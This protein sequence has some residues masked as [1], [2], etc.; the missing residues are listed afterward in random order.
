M[1]ALN[2]IGWDI[3][4]M[5]WLVGSL[6]KWLVVGYEDRLVGSFTSVSLTSVAHA[7]FFCLICL[8][9]SQLLV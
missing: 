8:A 1:G 3:G 6:V 5:G 2:R 7:V 4:I 9:G